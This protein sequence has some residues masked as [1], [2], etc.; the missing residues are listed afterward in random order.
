MSDYH[1]EVIECG[2]GTRWAI[3]AHR[4]VGSQLQAPAFPYMYAYVTNKYL[5]AIPALLYGEILI[6]LPFFQSP[7]QVTEF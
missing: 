6:S 2:F 5:G 7:S 3:W 4:C 1:F